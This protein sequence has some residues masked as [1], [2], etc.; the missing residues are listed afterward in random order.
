MFSKSD[1]LIDFDLTDAIK[2]WDKT[3]TETAINAVVADYLK[4]APGR[5]TRSLLTRHNAIL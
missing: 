1:S 3:A 2:R 4:H 5:L